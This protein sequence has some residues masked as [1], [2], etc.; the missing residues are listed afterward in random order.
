MVSYSLTKATRT[1]VPYSKFMAFM[2]ER[3]ISQGDVAKVTGKRR[4]TINQNLNGTS[5]QLSLDD[6]RKICEY[7]GISSDEYFV[8]KSVS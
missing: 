2:I 3:N 5:G 4:S 8:V 1:K 6:V 7:W